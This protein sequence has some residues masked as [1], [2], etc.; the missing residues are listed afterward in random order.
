MLSLQGRVYV[1]TRAVRA[2]VRTCVYYPCQVW[3]P[4]LGHVC[5][6]AVGYTQGQ[7][8]TCPCPECSACLCDSV[9]R[10]W[11]PGAVAYS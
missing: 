5:A 8:S 4:Y 1:S 3:C 9:R 11:T 10:V 6:R 7:S 2:C